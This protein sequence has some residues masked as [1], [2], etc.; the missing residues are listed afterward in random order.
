MNANLSIRGLAFCMPVMIPARM[1]A[2]VSCE[3]DGGP[4]ST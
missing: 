2:M 1:S 4:V 3:V